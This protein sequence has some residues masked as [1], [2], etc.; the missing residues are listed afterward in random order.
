VD[1]RTEPV[2]FTPETSAIALLEG[3]Q[4]KRGGDGNGHAARRQR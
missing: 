2:Q 1:V 3:E 4:T